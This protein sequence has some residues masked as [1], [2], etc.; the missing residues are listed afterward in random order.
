MRAAEMVRRPELFRLA[1]SERAVPGGV[2]AKGHATPSHFSSE[3]FMPTPE[4]STLR[5]PFWNHC[6]DRFRRVQFSAQ[7]RVRN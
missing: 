3:C 2:E 5:Q 6:A 7:Q 4:L 1:K